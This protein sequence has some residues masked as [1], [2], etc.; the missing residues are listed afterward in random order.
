MSLWFWLTKSGYL[1][2]KLINYE[3]L[4]SYFTRTHTVRLSF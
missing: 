4:H 2:K 1:E 3:S